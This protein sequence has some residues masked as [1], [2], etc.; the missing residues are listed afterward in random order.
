MN[1]R[2]LENY[3]RI[4]I[5]QIK[6]DYE[7]YHV[8]TYKTPYLPYQFQL[9]SGSKT[10]M[11]KLYVIFHLS[12]HYIEL[13][14]NRVE[15]DTTPCNYG[16]NRWWC[17]CPRCGRRCAILYFNDIWQCRKCLN[18]VYRS[19]QITKTNYWYYYHRAERIARQL[20]PGY[21]ADGFDYLLTRPVELFPNKPK[22]IKQITY[23]R[24]FSQFCYLVQRG[25]ISNQ[26]ELTRVLNK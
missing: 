11:I 9:T 1:Q 20:D 12:D 21:S 13:N 4:D 18:L 17:I 16:G 14:N 10:A 5:R 3:F 8:A 7:R 22:Y 19:S 23:Q 15:L 2:T 24:L 26:K 6:R 25:N